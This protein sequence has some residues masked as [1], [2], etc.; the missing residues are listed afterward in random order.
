MIPISLRP[1]ISKMAP[2][3]PYIKAVKK[4]HLADICT[5]S[6]PSSF[7]T[8]LNDLFVEKFCSCAADV[9]NITTD[10]KHLDGANSDES[11]CRTP[12]ETLSRKSYIPQDI[13]NWSSEV[14]LNVDRRE[15]CT[16]RNSIVLGCDASVA[17]DNVVLHTIGDATLSSHSETARQQSYEST[18]S[19]ST[20]KEDVCTENAI[21]KLLL[22]GR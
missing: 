5:L 18:R 1:V 11:L 6:A 13:G 19:A 2:S 17:V 15:M 12:N 8:C 21:G 3:Q 16:N 14:Q 4:T 9:H 10:V 22:Y 20:M 7:I